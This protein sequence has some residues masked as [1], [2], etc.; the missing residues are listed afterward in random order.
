[1]ETSPT[2]Q[3]IIEAATSVFSEKGKD[4]ARMQEIANAAG[5]NKALLHY[6]FRS[7]HKL[8]R[9]VFLYQ[10]KKL[11]GSIFSAIKDDDDFYTFLNT[12]V[13]RYIEYIQS[14]KALLRFIIW[15]IGK[16]DPELF[17]HVQSTFSEQGYS[18][19][20]IIQ[21]TRQAIATGQIK[22]IDPV[23]FTIS[24]LGMCIFPFITYQFI[25]KIIPGADVNDPQF[26]SKRAE[27]IVRVI[28]DG[29][30]AD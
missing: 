23:H 8:F 7:K 16:E 17:N 14:R 28:W 2:E 4:G 19:N 13:T 21:K 11:I 6:Y 29:I 3:K 1:M 10:F 20:P 25:G 18:D 30:K 26:M 22:S 5:I 24:L 27:E 12:F 9:I 15:E